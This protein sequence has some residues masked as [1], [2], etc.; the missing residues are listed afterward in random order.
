MS[1]PVSVYTSDPFEYIGGADAEQETETETQV[2]PAIA[3]EGYLLKKSTKLLIGWQVSRLIVLMDTVAAVVS[4]EG[5]QAALLQVA[6]ERRRK[7]AVL[8]D[9]KLR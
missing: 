3:K 4:I 7:R 2:R 5:S 9:Y 1:S 8:R 6:G